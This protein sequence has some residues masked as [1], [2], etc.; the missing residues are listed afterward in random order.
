MVQSERTEESWNS[1]AH[2]LK[3]VAEKVC[4]QSKEDKKHGGGMK[5]LPRLLRGKKRG[6]RNGG[7][8][9]TKR[10]CRRIRC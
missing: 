7:K 5:R 4:G 6:I 3:K 8:T 2:C 1:L 9:E 10:I